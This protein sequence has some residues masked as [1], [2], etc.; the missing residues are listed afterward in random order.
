MITPELFSV[1][2]FWFYTIGVNICP[3]DTRNKRISESWKPMQTTAMSV[4]EYEDLKKE[5]AFIR[6]A[7]VVTGKVWRGDHIGY[8]LNGVDLDNEKAIQ[9]ICNASIL[10]GKAAT[11][12]ELASMNV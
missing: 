4:K 6:G 12:Q 3:A 9:E 11:L 1:L 8:Y 2:D 10:D 7:A 5:G